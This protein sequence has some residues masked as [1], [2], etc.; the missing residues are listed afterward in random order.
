MSRDRNRV[1]FKEVKALKEDM[2]VFRRDRN[3]VE[4]KAQPPL[5]T[6]HII[7]VEIGT[8]WNLKNTPPIFLP[9]KHWR[10]DRNRVEFKER[11]RIFSQ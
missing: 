11:L 9:L 4:F 5:V 10:R 3:R 8:E 7:C 6:W 1:E 2:P